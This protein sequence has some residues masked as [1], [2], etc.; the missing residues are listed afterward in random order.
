MNKKSF[1]LILSMLVINMLHA[2]KPDWMKPHPEGRSAFVQG[3]LVDRE[4]SLKVLA[5]EVVLTN[6]EN[7]N[8]SYTFST[9][10]TGVFQFHL[11]ENSIYTASFSSN[12]YI[13]RRIEFN[14][15]D[16]PAKAWK[17]GCDIDVKMSLDIKPNGFKELVSV[18]PFAS[19]KYDL[20]E[21]LFLFDVTKTDAVIE[22][23]E[24]ELARARAAEKGTVEPNQPQD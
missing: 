5:G 23:Y 11:W 6:V 13:T 1:I 18:L 2:Q 10:S 3:L 15:H 8:E 14:T 4:D 22:R 12:G 20:D 21:R 7:S 24:Q 16:V 19:F 17:K 9:T